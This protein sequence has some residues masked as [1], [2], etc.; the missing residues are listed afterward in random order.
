MTQSKSRSIQLI[1]IFA[2]LTA[3]Y[4]ISLFF[5]SILIPSPYETACAIWEITRT[6]QLFEQ[7][8]ISLVR[9]IIG[10][11]IGA[12]IAISLGIM[13][14]LNETIYEA[15]RPVTAI[16][17]GIPPIILV[18]LALVWF[19]TNSSIAIFVVSI[20]IFPTFFLNIAN[21]FR[22]MDQQLLDMAKVYQKS[23]WVLLKDI[24]FPSLMVPLF[25]A[26]SIAFGSAVRTTVMAELL[27]ASDGIGASLSMARINI[28]TDVVFAWTVISI[29]LIIGIDYLILKPMKE[30]LFQWSGD[31]K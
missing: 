30:K 21:G 1:S 11:T 29:L 17:M 16:L 12:I 14:G 18:V 3:W 9:M 15:F 26:C 13:A 22:Q 6:G 8:S 10:F 24:I 20:L 31:P 2:L 4:I 25:T 23:K 27:G 5:P 19:G 7:L 28:N